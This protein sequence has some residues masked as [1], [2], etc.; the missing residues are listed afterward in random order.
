MAY[1]RTQKMQEEL[2]SAFQRTV[3]TC[4]VYHA[5]E[6]IQDAMKA[7]PLPAEVATDQAAIVGTLES[8]LHLCAKLTI[9]SGNRKGVKLHHLPNKEG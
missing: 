5:F 4:G 7:D 2:K 3:A 6:A 8:L 1:E 9:Q